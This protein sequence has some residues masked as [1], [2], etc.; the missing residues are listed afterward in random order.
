MNSKYLIKLIVYLLALVSTWQANAQ[1]TITAKMLEEIKEHPQQDTFRVNLLNRVAGSGTIT[2]PQKNKFAEEALYISQKIGYTKGEGYALVSIARAQAQ[3]VGK[4]GALIMLDKADSIAN[5]TRNTDLH[6]KVLSARSLCWRAYDNKK[7]L[8][9]SLQAEA[10]AL[11]FG[12]RG[13]LSRMEMNIGQIYANAFNNYSKGLEYELRA[14]NS[15]EASGNPLNKPDPWSVI[16]YIYSYMGDYN[17]AI[18]YAQKILDINKQL[19]SPYVQWEGTMLMALV[20]SYQKKYVASNAYY[21]EML[22]LDTTVSSSELTQSNIAENYMNVDSLDTALAYAFPS[23][24]TAKK[25]HDDEGVAFIDAIIAQVYVKKNMP[26]SAIAYAKEGLTIARRVG[27]LDFMSSNAKALTNAFLLKKDYKNAF[28]N[29][30]LAHN[31][32]DSALNNDVKNKTASLEYNFNLEKKQNEIQLLDQQKKSQQGFLIAVSVVLLLI[33]VSAIILLRSNQLKQKAKTKIERAYS[34]LKAMQA[35]LIQ[36]EKMASLGELT[37]GIAHEIQNPLNFVNNFSELN[38]ELM[39]EMEHEFKSGNA[40][41]AFALAETI[42]QNIDKVN[43]HGKRAGAIVKSMLQ[44][45]RTSGGQKELVDINALADEY[46]RL[47]Y[48]G[49]KSRNESFDATIRSNFDVAVG[50][51][52]IIPADLG[53]VLINIYNNAFYAVAEKKRKQPHEYEPVVTVSTKREGDIIKISTQDNGTGIPDN[54]CQKIFQP[55][56]TTK[57]TGQGTGLG[58]SLSYDIIKANGG[59]IKVTS[60][61]GKGSEFT[62]CLPLI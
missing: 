21:K 42:K 40:T 28:D 44:H 58:L 27:S 45:S 59:E 50:S 8:D 2:I 14:I 9:Y 37:A 17:K 53:R 10:Q 56:F 15:A 1:T 23:L 26:D 46:L 48:Q 7:S 32:S 25:I 5:T 55:F 62:V 3:S 16:A 4:D 33:M 39:Q 20:L 34:E 38:A 18:V 54:I 51:I 19:G 30:V 57:P 31:Y 61:D 22:S 52:N 13:L 6:I 29:S 36:S 35:Q 12:E 49:F 47:S 41:D 11:K 24:A 43:E 60:E